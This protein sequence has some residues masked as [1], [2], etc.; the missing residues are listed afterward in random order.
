MAGDYILGLDIGGTKTAVVLGDRTGRV[1]ERVEFPTAPERGVEATLGDIL[2]GGEE[3]RDSAVEKGRA[4]AVV[5]VSIGGPLDTERGVI[6]NPPNLPGWDAVPLKDRLESRLGL[7]CH[8]EHDGN[9]GAL[10]EWYFGAA[11]GA[12]DAIFLTMG[13]GFG[14]GLILGGR[15]CRG[16]CDMA[17]EVGHVRLSDSGPEAYGKVGCWEAF[18]SGTGIVRLAATRAPLR[19]REDGV[20]VLELA[21]LARAGDQEAVDVFRTVGHYLGRG[22]AVLVDVLNPEVIVIG[23][24]AVRL[25]DLVL[26]PARDEMRREALG[27]AVAAVRVVPA[28][29]GESVGDVASLCAGIMALG[30]PLES[31]T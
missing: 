20:T 30:G 29:L 22:L 27:R 6:Y 9:A 18:C 3:A 13:T 16:A 23:S 19:W 2:R 14:G 17:G 10:A 21:D 1:H 25:G 26:A 31:Q 15:L 4:P 24:L 5:S 28:A 12:R 7:P 8:V 11:K